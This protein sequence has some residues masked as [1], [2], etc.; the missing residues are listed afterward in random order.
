MIFDSVLGLLASVWEK[1]DQISLVLFPV[2][3]YTFLVWNKNQK[4][5]PEEARSFIDSLDELVDTS[6]IS[7]DEYKKR[8][9][10]SLLIHVADLIQGLRVIVA[11]LLAI[12]A[13]LLLS[14]FQ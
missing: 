5:Y 6:Y 2:L 9:L 3:V 12:L 7:T 1:A 10:A 11:A 4:T 8:V 14:A 13:F